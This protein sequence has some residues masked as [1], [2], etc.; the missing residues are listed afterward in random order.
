M[1]CSPN[2]DFASPI[3]HSGAHFR[4]PFQSNVVPECYAPQTKILEDWT[5]RCVCVEVLFKDV[6][7]RFGPWTDENRSKKTRTQALCSV[8]PNVCSP[9]EDFGRLNKAL[10]ARFWPNFRFL[11]RYC[12]YKNHSIRPDAP[13]RIGPYASGL[14]LLAR[15][16]HRSCLYKKSQHQTRCTG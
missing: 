4:S 9:N 15:F 16:L 12:L 5:Q 3:G 7:T 10:R 6:S 8:V 2:E 11:D 1:L 13:D 14:S